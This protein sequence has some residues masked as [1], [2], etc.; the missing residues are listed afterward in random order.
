[1]MIPVRRR[2]V[3]ATISFIAASVILRPL[4]ADALCIRGDE[5]LRGGDPRTAA[6]YYR[7]ALAGDANCGT[8]AERFAF[9]ALEIHTR[10]VLE[11]AI[12]AADA[13]LRV[14]DDEAIRI[15]RALALWDVND[16]ARATIELRALG[17]ATH[18]ERYTR[19]A[20]IAARR[21]MRR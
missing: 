19:L 9:A 21:R 13:Y 20:Q 7:L 5:F 2:C 4:I 17:A 14:H 10:A 18:D 1:M 3:L 11:S 12:R 6:H 15:D 16:F 8:A